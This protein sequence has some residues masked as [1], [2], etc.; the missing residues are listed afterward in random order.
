LV[1]GDGSAKPRGL[2][3]DSTLGVTGPSGTG[4]SFGA[5]GTAGQGTDLLNDLYSSLAEP[6][7]RSPALAWL[8][9][10]PTLG[11]IRKLKATTG[12]LVGNAFAGPPTVPGAQATMLGAGVFLDP[13]MAAM[14]NTAKSTVLADMSRYFV[15]IAGGLRFERSDDFAFQSDL[16][17]FRARI[18]LDA[19][20]VDTTG[21]SK[22]FVHTT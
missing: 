18:R 15:R 14:A 16:I 20:L 13:S 17:S 7:T 4:T 9:R 8:M 5:Q 2:I 1:T 6:Y 12:E 21:A 3:T 11:A 19:A 22:Y 10:T